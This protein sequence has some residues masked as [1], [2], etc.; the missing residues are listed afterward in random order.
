MFHDNYDGT[1]KEPNVLPAKIPFIF[2]NG[3][4]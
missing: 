2:L 3:T 4:T 1:L